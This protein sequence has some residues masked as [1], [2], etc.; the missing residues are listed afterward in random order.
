[1]NADIMNRLPTTSR[2]SREQQT[3]QPHAPA[4]LVHEGNR[5]ITP[6]IPEG[7]FQVVVV[8]RDFDRMDVGGCEG[9]IQRDCAVERRSRVVPGIPPHGEAV[10]KAVVTE[11]EPGFGVLGM[12]L[13]GLLQH[14]HASR[15]ESVKVSRGSQSPPR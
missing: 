13:H 9:R 7:K 6:D 1:M 4:V 8:Q 11:L 5:Q 12:P 3:Q 14:G 10:V 2:A 15:R